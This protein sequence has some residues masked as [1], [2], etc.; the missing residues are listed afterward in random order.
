MKKELQDELADVFDKR[1]QAEDA[2]LAREAE[3]KER[4]QEAVA[5]FTKAR[6]AVII[7]A[8]QAV[9]TI[10]VDRGFAFALGSSEDGYHASD[11]RDIPASVTML[12]S[13][14][15]KV[16]LYSPHARFQAGPFFQAAF[17]KRTSTV[18]FSHCCRATE[19]RNPSS[20]Q[21]GEIPLAEITPAIVQAKIVETIKQVYRATN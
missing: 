15:D 7:P 20:A 3:Q 12:L 17:D 16:R 6:D 2:R 9:G 19:L 4:D 18:K 11:K 1:S 5:K 8:M 21:C 10:V 14:T 13:M